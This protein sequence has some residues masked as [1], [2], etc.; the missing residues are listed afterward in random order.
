ME[1]AGLGDL[2]QVVTGLAG[3]KAYQDPTSDLCR[4]TNGI[5]CVRDPK[6]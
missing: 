1:G 4:L 2:L 3:L 5:R 6:P